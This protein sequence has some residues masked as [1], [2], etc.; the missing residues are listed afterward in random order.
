MLSERDFHICVS[1]SNFAGVR[2]KRY[3]FGGI[4]RN[5]RRHKDAAEGRVRA[6]EDGIPARGHADEPLPA[7]TRAETAGRLLGHESP[8]ARVGAHVRRF[9][10]LSAG[11]SVPTAHEL[12]GTSS[13]RSARH[14]RGRRA[15]LQLPRGVAFRASGSRVSQLPRFREGP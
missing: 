15:G 6:G 10:G 7:Q 11:E 8:V 5:A 14:V 13:A 1:T 3:G 12:G 2:R 9:A 4:G